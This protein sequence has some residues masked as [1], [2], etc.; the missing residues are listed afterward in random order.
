MTEIIPL[1]L[2]TITLMIIFAVDITR[3]RNGQAN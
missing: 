3:K 2:S 1:A